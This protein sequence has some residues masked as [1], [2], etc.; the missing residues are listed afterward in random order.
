MLWLLVE[1]MQIILLCLFAF[2]K[3]RKRVYLKKLKKARTI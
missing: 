3:K 1:C 2:A